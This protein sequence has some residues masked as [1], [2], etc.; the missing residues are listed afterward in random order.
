MIIAWN[1]CKVHFGFCGIVHQKLPR[2]SQ[3]VLKKA[4]HDSMIT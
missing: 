2:L 1:D 3:F 4:I